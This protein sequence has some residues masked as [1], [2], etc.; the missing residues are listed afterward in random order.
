M[1]TSSRRYVNTA[2]T[3]RQLK[4]ARKH[5]SQ[6]QQTQNALKLALRI[7]KHPNYK[8]ANIIAG[9]SAINGEISLTPLMKLAIAQGKQWL[10]PEINN[11]QLLFRETKQRTKT[12][13]NVFGIQEVVG[14]Q[15]HAIERID[16]FLCPL[17]AFDLQGNRIGMG[18][19]FYDRALKVLR[20]KRKA[21]IFGVAH[22]LQRVI[23]IKPNK[24]DIRLEGVFTPKCFFAAKKKYEG[25]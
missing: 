21:Y 4:L 20:K 7:A 14:A 9:Y 2:D 25:R 8:H 11:D 19:G 17:V 6:Q 5:L 22:D 12:R 16:L 1:N 18:A 23:G 10:T 13:S 24:W 15:V 3:R